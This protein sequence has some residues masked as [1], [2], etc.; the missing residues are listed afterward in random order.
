MRVDVDNT[1]EVVERAI[2][3][4]S[5]P[6]CYNYPKVHLWRLPDTSGVRERYPMTSKRAILLFLLF[7]N[8]HPPLSVK[9]AS[10][11][12]L[13]RTLEH[14]A[15][16]SACWARDSWVRFTDA[17]PLQIPVKFYVEAR[18]RERT[19]PMFEDNGF[20]E[21]DIL[22]FDGDP[23]EPTNPELKPHCGKKL[24]M[25]ADERLAAYD[26]V[27]QADSDL[28]VASPEGAR[29]PF[30]ANLFPRPQELGSL[31]INL[32]PSSLA[33]DLRWHTFSGMSE[34][35]WFRIVGEYSTPRI[36][37]MY[38]MKEPPVASIHGALTLFPAR[39]FFRERQS[40]LEWIVK[41][42][43]ELQ[44]D[45]AVL[46]VWRM[47]GKPIWSL[48]SDRPES[49]HLVDQLED[50]QKLRQRT[51]DEGKAVYLSHFNMPHEWVWRHDIGGLA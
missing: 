11:A 50:L 40:E 42:G 18:T 48:C 24:A 46:S 21:D 14:H 8:Q 31:R 28:F 25:F 5:N 17:V 43:I 45:E 9:E 41:L 39:R 15:V 30:F 35:E 10:H 37:S 3:P 1:K 33:D 29:Y 4:V 51:L 23:F 16:R 36:A 7:Q 6:R 26:W 20:T 34:S 27:L 47:R 2:D 22:W 19:L 44:D 49:L 13:D 32:E 12:E 38:A